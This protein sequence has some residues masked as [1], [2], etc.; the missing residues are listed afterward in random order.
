M[1]IRTK[2]ECPACHFDLVVKR[3]GRC[4]NCGLPISE[5]V[6]RVR[7]RERRIEQ[8]VAIIGSLLV[9][10]LFFLTTGVSLGLLEGVA[11]YA[12]VGAA[13]FFLARKTF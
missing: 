8:T 10:A 5:H 2:I 3:G 11:V 4:P 13:M 12:A 7:A 9:L 1:P 6:A